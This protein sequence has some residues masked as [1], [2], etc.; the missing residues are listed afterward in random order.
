MIVKKI[1]LTK[2]VESQDEYTIID[3]KLKE[4]QAEKT[5]KGKETK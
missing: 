5:P 4:I 2:L 3:G 1:E